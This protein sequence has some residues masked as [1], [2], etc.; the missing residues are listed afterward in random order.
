MSIEDAIKKM[1]D[2]IKGMFVEIK[3]LQ[4]TWCRF[5]TTK[6]ESGHG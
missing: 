6:I 4:K 1:T 5:L 2:L 3:A